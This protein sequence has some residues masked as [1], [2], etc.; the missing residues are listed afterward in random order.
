VGTWTSHLMIL[1]L[2][3]L[4]TLVHVDLDTTVIPRST[5][6]MDIG[7]DRAV[8]LGMGDGKLAH[9]RVRASAACFAYQSLACRTV[10]WA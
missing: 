9:W 8:L 4:T 10:C 1:S 5:L 2:P 3:A 6:F 7:D